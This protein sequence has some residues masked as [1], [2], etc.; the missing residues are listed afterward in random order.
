MFFFF[1]ANFQIWVSDIM[2]KKKSYRFKYS[3]PRYS[4]YGQR[5]PFR[6]HV[7]TFHLSAL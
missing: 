7:S 5:N 3:K 6:L 1:I 2:E 4:L